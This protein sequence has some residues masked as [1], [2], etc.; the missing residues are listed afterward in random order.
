MDCLKAC[1]PKY[2]VTSSYVVTVVTT[3]V[4]LGNGDSSFLCIFCHKR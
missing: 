3:V 2:T 4:H 1:M